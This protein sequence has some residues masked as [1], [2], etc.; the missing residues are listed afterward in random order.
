MVIQREFE[1]LEN[2]VR[3]QGDPPNSIGVRPNDEAGGFDSPCTE[4]DSLHPFQTKV[5]VS[6]VCWCIQTAVTRL[7]LGRQFDSSHGPPN[8]CW[9]LYK[10]GYSFL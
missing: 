5:R 9:P 7:P 10:G 6:K 4:F 8:R 2:L 1:E 3:F